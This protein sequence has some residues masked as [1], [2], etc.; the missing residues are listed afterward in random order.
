MKKVSLF[1]VVIALLVWAWPVMIQRV[2]ADLSPIQPSPVALSSLPTMTPF[3]PVAFTLTPSVTPT[4]TQTPL[5]TIDYKATEEML[6]ETQYA[7]QTEQT[8]ATNIAQEAI[9]RLT[10]DSVEAEITKNQIERDNEKA[11]LEAETALRL[12]QIQS[13]A[14]TISAQKT[15]Q[16]EINT[17]EKDAKIALIQNDRENQIKFNNALSLVIRALLFISGFLALVIIIIA[18]NWSGKAIKQKGIKAR[19]DARDETN[20]NNAYNQAIL[21]DETTKDLADLLAASIQWHEAEG[22]KPGSEQTQIIPSDKMTTWS[23]ERWTQAVNLMVGKYMVVKVQGGPPKNQGT[24]IKVGNLG[25]WY[26][27]V[28]RGQFNNPD[29]L[30]GIA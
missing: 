20:W 19:R 1:V 15:A 11:L 14:D 6:R 8:Q 2:K 25:K 22:R 28:I 27:S 24:F 23:G 7:V 4:A 9:Y 3:Q 30:K 18:Y 13:E 5:P 21:L 16:A 26:Q 12:T 10:A 17:A 29:P